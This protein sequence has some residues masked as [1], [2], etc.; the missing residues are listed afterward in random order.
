MVGGYH[1]RQA[2]GLVLHRHA[3][4]LIS[5]CLSRCLS[6]FVVR[7]SLCR[8]L[9]LQLLY[10]ANLCQAVLFESGL[11][12]ASLWTC[13]CCRVNDPSSHDAHLLQKLPQALKSGM[14]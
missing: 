5:K 9:W 4:N 8:P 3:A 13:P 14:N 12:S 7:H 2:R 6:E 11:W 10:H 1:T